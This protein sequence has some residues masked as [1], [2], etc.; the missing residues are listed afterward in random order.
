MYIPA[1]TVPHRFLDCSR[2]N[3]NDSREFIREG[4]YCC[5][6]QMEYVENHES[7]ICLTRVDISMVV[8][9]YASDVIEYNRKSP[10][11]DLSNALHHITRDANSID[12]EL[13]PSISILELELDL[14][15]QQLHQKIES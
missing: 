8:I 3:Q 2:G 10:R 6:K 5:V 4:T 12:R 11:T 13:D 9:C 7:Q 15:R 14:P 1:L